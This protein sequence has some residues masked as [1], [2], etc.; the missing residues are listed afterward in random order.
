LPTYV[1][2]RYTDILR[3]LIAQPIM[4]LYGFLL[5]FT[6]AT[7]IQKRNPHDYFNDFIQEIPMYE[8][9][10]KVIELVLKAASANVSIE[11]NLINAYEALY[12]G[13]IVIDKELE[14]L[15]AWLYDL[16]TL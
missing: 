11:D 8:T 9:T 15:N 4:W 6:E 3:G 1:T 16:S 14:N 7:V 13:K 2:F 12:R 5:G 10:Q